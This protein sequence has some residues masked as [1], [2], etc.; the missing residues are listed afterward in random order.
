MDRENSH[1][2]TAVTLAG[3]TALL[4]TMHHKEQVIAPI[5]EERLGIRVSVPAGF[6]SDRFGTFTRDIDRAGTQVEAAR[7]KA[8]AVLEDSDC[9]LA[10]ASEGSFG[11]YP[12]MPW[13]PCDRELVLLLDRQHD[14]ELVGEAVSVETNYRQQRVT[15]VEEAQTFALQAGFPAHA[16]IVRADP[17]RPQPLWKGITDGE[18]LAERVQTQIRLQGS[19]WLETDMR[20]LYNPSRLQVIAA[21]T[22]DLVRRLQQVC[23]Q[24]AWPGFE[25]IRREPGL[26]CAACGS[27]TL[28]IRRQIHGCDRCGHQIV[29][30]YPQGVRVMD[31]GQ[32][33]FCN[34]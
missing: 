16:L 4:A 27:P 7:K 25:V 33:A 5:L 29:E 23:P 13:L 21:A 14:L 19:A 28:G 32:C 9:T 3:R 2:Q 22:Q 15:S 12:A 20:A 1:S 26:R 6:N 10:L 18:V 17:D 11:P 8:Q 31:P 24:C 34:P 30:D